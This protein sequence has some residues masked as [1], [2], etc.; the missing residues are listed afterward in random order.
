M[1]WLPVRQRWAAALTANGS[2]IVVL[3]EDG[4]LSLIA[5]PDWP[6]QPGFGPVATAR[7]DTPE[8]LAELPDGTILVG[9]SGG[10]VAVAAQQVN[11]WGTGRVAT[12]V[13]DLGTLA[14]GTV[15]GLQDWELRQ[16][17]DGGTGAVVPLGPVLGLQRVVAVPLFRVRPFSRGSTVRALPTSSISALPRSPVT[18]KVVPAREEWR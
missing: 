9:V 16:W 11:G 5:G 10:I 17:S 6:L 15:L 12:S 13:G 14:D 8:G 1:T 4:G 18:A 3:E 2:R 7:L